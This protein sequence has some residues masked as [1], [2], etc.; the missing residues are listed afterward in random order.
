MSDHTFDLQAPYQPAGDQPE[1]IRQL[2]AGIESG[3]PDQVLLGVTGSGK[4]FTIANVIAQ[5]NRPT[6]V[7]SHNKTLAAQLYGEF[8]EFFPN[9]LVEYFISY[10]DYYQPEAFIPSTNTYIEKDLKIN[11]DIEKLRLRATTALCMDRRDV[12]VIA[13]VSCIYGIGKPEDFEAN[14]YYAN[15]G[16]TISQN[17]FLD[18]LVRLFYSRTQTELEPGNFRV[19]GDT[20]DVYP[21]Y[22]DFGVR[23]IFFGD[24]IESIHRINVQTGRKVEA[25]RDYTLYPSNLFVTRRETLNDAIHLIQDDLVQQVKYFEDQGMFIEAN[26][27]KERTEFDLEMMRELGYCSGI[28]NYSRYLSQREAGSRPYCL[29]DYFP[30]DFLMVVDE[31]HVTIPQVRGMYHGDRSRKFTLVE[32]GFRLPSALDNRPLKFDEFRGLINQTLYLSATPS[33]YELEESGG[34]VV[35]QI[36]RPTGLLDPPVEIRPCETQVDDLLEEVDEEVKKGNRVLVTTLTKRM[37]E[38]LTRYLHDLGVASRYIHSDID[39]LERV[40]IL[41]EL[42]EGKFDVLVG[43]NLLREGIDLPEV[44]LV[45]ILDADKEGFLRSGQSLIQTAGRAA[46]HE[47]GR[48]ILYADKITKSMKRLIDETNYRR[49]KQMAYNEEHGITPKSVKREHKDIFQDTLGSRAKNFEEFEAKVTQTAEAAAEYLTDE[50]LKKK[51]ANIRKE[52]EAAAKE[53]N[54]IEAAR[55]RDELFA[56]QGLL[57]D[58]K[59]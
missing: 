55:L 15:I 33:D 13:S 47:K 58:R 34:V 25:L 12:I 38:E 36:V 46:R 51:I 20:V 17:Q 37:S 49:E 43:V 11:Q 30:D 56:F 4:T 3:E 8:K 19:K 27:V 26:R 14:V 1:A 42:R 22:D 32:H 41:R 18:K 39:A 57:K 45:A 59:H 50:E 16:Q 29:L 6:L 44:S 54:F 7:I 9:N 40:D 53:L 48:V 21:A 24:E 52:M 28:E 23:F 31:S 5:L 35:E 10:Y 2:I